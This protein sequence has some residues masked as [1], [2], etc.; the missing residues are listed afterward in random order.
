M[1]ASSLN[2]TG[3]SPSLQLF[4]EIYL[5][6]IHPG[7]KPSPPWDNANTYLVKAD[8]ASSQK[9]SGL[10]PPFEIQTCPSSTAVHLWVMSGEAYSLMSSGRLVLSSTVIFTSTNINQR[11]EERGEYKSLIEKRGKVSGDI[12][13]EGRVRLDPDYICGEG[14]E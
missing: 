10:L 7:Q 4:I 8:H 5:S 3:R 12:S 2:I 9:P 13:T 14:P 1:I 6:G 11:W